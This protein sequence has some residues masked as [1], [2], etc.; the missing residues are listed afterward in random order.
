MSNH[1]KPARA[2]SRQVRPWKQSRGQKTAERIVTATM[3][4]L[5]YHDFDTI[6]VD[7]IVQKAGT[8]K[9]AFYFRFE[10]KTHLLRHI[11]EIYYSQWLGESELFFEQN[12]TPACRLGQFLERFIEEA[13]R[14]YS[15][16]RNLVRAL[17][18]EARPGGDDVVLALVRS[19]TLRTR[20][21]LLKA[22]TRRKSQI[23]HPAPEVAIPVVALMIGTVVRQA[24]LFSE[25]MS[26][27]HGLTL[28]AVGVEV[29]RMARTYL[30]L[31]RNRLG[32]VRSRAPR[33]S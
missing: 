1:S 15:T 10:T 2:P 18:K 8:S 11:S 31:Q 16:N 21:L 3:E 23:R 30:G 17:L 4:L 28:N 32:G 13:V 7:Q 25:E 24:L 12:D 19:G 29:K 14:F 27:V 9:G 26:G 5:Q 20:G 6:A 33:F 22:L